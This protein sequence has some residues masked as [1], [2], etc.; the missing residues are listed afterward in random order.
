MTEIKICGLSRLEDIEY[1]NEAAPDY[2][3]FIIE[4]PK[5]HRSIDIERLK[6]LRARLNPH[7]QAVGVFVDAPLS[8]VAAAANTD[9]VDII[10]LHGNEDEEYISS[11]RTN[12]NKRIIKAFQVRDREDVIK[13][14]KSSADYILLDSGQGTGQSFD[15][16]LLDG[17]NR[18]FFL[19]GGINLDNMEEAVKKLQPYALDISS[20]VESDKKKDRAKIIEAVKRLRIINNRQKETR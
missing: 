17:I 13:A 10:Q 1:V 20:G 12:T 3:G 8:L 16:K 19:A 2:A 15:W 6:K 9:L 5:S 18:C 4:F 11:L 14:E 7:I